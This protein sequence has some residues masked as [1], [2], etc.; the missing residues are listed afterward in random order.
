[1]FDVGWPELLVILAVALLVFGPQ[2][3]VE[4]AR[5]VGKTLREFR[6]ITD[7]ASSAFTDILK[8]EPLEPPRD[9]PPAEAPAAE[10]T[11]EPTA[12]EPPTFAGPLTIPPAGHIPPDEYDSADL[13]MPP[14]PE[15][16][17]AGATPADEPDTP[18]AEA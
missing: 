3:M 10:T 8:E 17:D 16:P 13:S 12:A 18:A 5:T 15:E 9:L 1:M 11:A 4:L 6:K 14:F 2:R 7:E